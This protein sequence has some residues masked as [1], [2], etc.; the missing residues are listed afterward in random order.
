[1]MAR[2]PRAQRGRPREDFFD[3]LDRFPIA[4]AYAL[5]T[6]GVSEKTAFLFVSAIVLGEPIDEQQVPARR[7]Q[8]VGAVH[9]GRLTTFERA[10]RIGSSPASFSSFADRLR[11]KARKVSRDPSAATWLLRV[12]SGI[13]LFLRIARESGGDFERAVKFIF[14]LAEA[15]SAPA[16]ASGAH[17]F[18]RDSTW[19]AEYPRQ[20]ETKPMTVGRRDLY[21]TL[22]NPLLATPGAL[23]DLPPK[24]VTVIID[25]DATATVI[26]MNPVA[27]CSPS[28][29]ALASELAQMIADW[30]KERA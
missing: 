7:K 29:A 23:F 15:A 17:L 3:D 12:Q 5:Q 4:V 11:K 25:A 8:G 30:M 1:M 16:V 6:L 9:A 10:R 19:G 13:A 18:P 28:P 27:L 22:S 26:R 14:D 2:L 24:N 20:Q 21:A